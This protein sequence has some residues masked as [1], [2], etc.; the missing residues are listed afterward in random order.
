MRN[1][2]NVELQR[3]KEV[4]SYEEEIKNHKKRNV[5]DIIKKFLT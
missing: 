4:I 2:G 3:R 5:C 1:E